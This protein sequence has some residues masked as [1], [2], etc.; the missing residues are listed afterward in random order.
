MSNLQ[1][2]RRLQQQSKIHSS[3]TIYL[4][5]SVARL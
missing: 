1:K 2:S 3:H 5:L 4:L